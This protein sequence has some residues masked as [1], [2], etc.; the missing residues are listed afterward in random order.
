MLHEEKELNVLSTCA[1]AKEQSK[2]SHSRVLDS[3]V[4]SIVEIIPFMQRSS[5]ANQVKYSHANI[6][7]IYKTINF[8]SGLLSML[9]KSLNETPMR[10]HTAEI[11]KK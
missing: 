1:I 10:R 8:P 9:H 2:K 11:T 3:A 7:K 6:E 5:S 4:A